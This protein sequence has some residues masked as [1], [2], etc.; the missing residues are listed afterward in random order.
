MNKQPT[1]TKRVQRIDC[2]LDRRRVVALR[3]RISSSQ[4]CPWLIAFGEEALPHDRH[5]RGRFLTKL[6]KKH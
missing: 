6:Y 4:F 2:T 1:P 3:Y 5:A